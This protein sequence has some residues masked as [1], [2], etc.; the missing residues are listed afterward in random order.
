ALLQVQV[1]GEGASAIA[2]HQ[3]PREG[4]PWRR[5]PAS[6]LRN[7]GEVRDAVTEGDPTEADL[8]LIPVL[9]TDIRP[10]P[11]VIGPQVPAEL[12]DASRKGNVLDELAAPGELRGRSPTP[13]HSAIRHQEPAGIDGVPAR[14]R[15]G[16]VLE[17]PIHQEICGQ[18]PVSAAAALTARSNPRQKVV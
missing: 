2:H 3:L 16:D 15:R 5:E 8:R 7:A 18:C 1:E 9:E 6:G 12:V 13:A 11:E 17:I 14:E 10:E 4:L